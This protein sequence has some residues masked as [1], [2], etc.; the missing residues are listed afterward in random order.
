[1]VR[2]TADER[3]QLGRMVRRGKA[4]ARALLP[5]FCGK[6]TT[7][8]RL[9]PGATKRSVRRWKCLPPRWPTGARV[10]CKKGW[11]PP[12]GLHPPGASTRANGTA[13]PK[14]T[15]SPGPVARHPKVKPTNGSNGGRSLRSRTRPSAAPG[16]KR[17]A[18]APEAVWG[19]AARA[20]CRSG[21]RA[22]R[23]ADGL[24]TPAGSGSSRPLPG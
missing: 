9:R 21:G 7:A 11:K 13:P 2:L 3:G 1:M 24:P 15:A 17:M 16:K 12:A 8:R 18:A 4:A 10:W 20:Q 14:R 23:G 6:P 22:G 19:D 5:V